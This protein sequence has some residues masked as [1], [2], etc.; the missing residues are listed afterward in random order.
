MQVSFNTYKPFTYHNRLNNQ[1]KQNTAPHFT[2]GYGA[3]DWGYVDESELEC[4]S[5]SERWRNIGQ[6]IKMMTV[7]AFKEAYCRD[8]KPKPLLYSP[9]ECK[10]AREEYYKGTDLEGVD[11]SNRLPK[12]EANPYVFDPWEDDF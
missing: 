9:E 10:K 5:E 8:P 12:E 4:C 11:T 2:S 3:D 1:P 6:A 7:D